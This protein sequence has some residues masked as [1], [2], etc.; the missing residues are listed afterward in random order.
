MKAFLL[1]VSAEM[2]RKFGY[3]HPMGENWRGYQDIDPATLTRERIVDFLDRVDPESILA[4]VPHGTPKQVARIDLRLCGRGPA[5]AQDPG[6]RRDGR[7]VVCRGVGGQRARSRGRADAIVRRCAVSGATGRGGHAGPGR[8]RHRPATTTATPRCR[9]G[10]ALAVDLLNGIGMDA[11]GQ[12]GGRR[13]VPLVAH[14]APGVL[15]GPQPLS[16]RRRNRRAADV[17]DRRATLGH[18]ADARADVGRSRRARPAVLGGDVPVPAARRS[19]GGDDP[20]RA[21]ADADW[22]EINAKMPK[23]LHSHPYNDMLGDGLP[24]DERTWAFDFRVMTPTAWWRVPMQTVVGG[25]PTDPR[26][27]VPHPQGDAAAVPVPPATEI[28]GAQGLSWLSA[29]GALRRLPRRQPA[30]AAP[31]PGAGRGVAHDDD[32]RHPGGHRRSHRPAGRGQDAPGADAREHRQHDDQPDGRT[33]RG[34]CMSA[35][36]TSSPTRSAPCAATTTS[37]VGH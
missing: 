14:L 34:S 9:H 19:R 24:E 8:G 26:G 6:L 36:R 10:S 27:A 23:W 12:A 30:V 22:R 4:V 29:Q 32:G 25:L 2:L 3:E 13:R 16:G 17:R 33:T 5:G 21:R 20:R 31:R 15:R 37:A 1:Q 18:H 28:L 35:T 11:D 7:A